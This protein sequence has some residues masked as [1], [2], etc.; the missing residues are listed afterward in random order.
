[1]QI[2]P[3]YLSYQIIIIIF[4]IL[5]SYILCFR[6]GWALIKLKSDLMV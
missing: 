3:G 1:M 5:V 4:F 2:E 6:M